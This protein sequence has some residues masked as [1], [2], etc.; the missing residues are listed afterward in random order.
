MARRRAGLSQ[1]DLAGKAGVPQSS[2]SRIE[3]SQI[4]PTVDTLERL[5]RACDQE[6]EPVS[7]PAERDL[8]WSQIDFHLEMTAAARA[9][10]AAS[11]SRSIQRIQRIARHTG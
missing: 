7:V 1:R 4:S 11:A 9:R 10:Y 6:L 5:L 2:I 8:D 3:R